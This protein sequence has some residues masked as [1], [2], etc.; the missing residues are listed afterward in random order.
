MA[1]RPWRKQRHRW[2]R[3]RLLFSVI[4]YALNYPQVKGFVKAADT[5][6]I[7]EFVR[8]IHVICYNHIL[9]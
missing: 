4:A 6:R 7:N 9:V 3:I 2:W 1:S 8:D 5:H